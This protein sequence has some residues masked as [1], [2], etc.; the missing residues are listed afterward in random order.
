VTCEAV[1]SEAQFLV[2]RFGGNPLLVLEFV[3]RGAV[4]VAF[5]VPK[6]INRLMQLQRTYRNVPM[7]LADACLVRMTEQVSR[8]RLVTTDSDFRFYRRNGRQQIPLLM[9][10]S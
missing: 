6:E 4:E 9:P 3:Q 8:C 7:S 10:E 5:N 2:G 1:L